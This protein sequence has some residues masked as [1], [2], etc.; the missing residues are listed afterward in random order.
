MGGS[1]AAA[2]I[3]AVLDLA[4]QRRQG[5]GSGR[6][7]HLSYAASWRLAGW[8]RHPLESSGGRRKGE[9]AEAAGGGRER[10][11]QAD[12]GGGGGRERE[13]RGGGSVDEEVACGTRIFFLFG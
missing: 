7:L 3:A 5:T 13:T 12:A 6:L 8:L 11:G 1:A 4:E 10:S 2:P 9:G